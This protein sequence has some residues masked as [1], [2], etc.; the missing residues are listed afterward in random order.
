[1]ALPPWHWRRTSDFRKRSYETL[2]SQSLASLLPKGSDSPREFRHLSLCGPGAQGRLCFWEGSLESTSF[3][4]DSCCSVL[5]AA[6]CTWWGHQNGADTVMYVCVC[7]CVCMCVHVRVCVCVCVCVK[8][9]SYYIRE[10]MVSVWFITRDVKI[11]HLFEVAFARL[12][13]CKVIFPFTYC[14]FGSQSL[15]LVYT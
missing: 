12:L 11:K 6:Q 5:F 1:M 7:V 13:C 8:C 4:L 14:L 10:H 9:S 3:R 2:N 15:N